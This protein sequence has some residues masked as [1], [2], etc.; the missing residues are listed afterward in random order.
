MRVVEREAGA[1]PVSEDDRF[2]LAREKCGAGIL[3]THSLVGY[4]LPRLP[5]GDRLAIDA[6][7]LGENGVCLLT[8]LNCSSDTWRRRRT[9]MRFTSRPSTSFSRHT[10]SPAHPAIVAVR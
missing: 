10:L 3:R 8:R 6:M 5:F 4:G 7:S 1:L 9:G 2:I